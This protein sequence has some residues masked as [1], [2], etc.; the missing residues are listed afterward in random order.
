[1]RGQG[2]RGGQGAPA[3][4]VEW[5]RGGRRE[6]VGGG[7]ELGGR[8]ERRRRVSGEGMATGSEELASRAHNEAR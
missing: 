6:L 7:A 2:V 8:G 5:A 4:G 3:G 1:M